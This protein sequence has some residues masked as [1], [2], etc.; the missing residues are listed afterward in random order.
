MDLDL[1]ADRLT[2]DPSIRFLLP[3]HLYGRSMNLQ[4]LQA[5]SERFGVTIIEDCAQAVRASSQNRDVGAVGIASA[6]SMYPTK[7]LGAI[8]DAGFIMTDDD[9]I[10]AAARNL[11][12]YGQ[13]QKYVHD[14]LGLN[15]RLD[16]IHAAILRDAMLPRMD[17]FMA[18]RRSIAEQYLSRIDNPDVQ[19]PRPDAGHVW[20]LFPVRCKAA[21]ELVTWLSRYEVQTGRHYPI[22]IPDQD[23]LSAY[24]DGVDVGGSYPVAQ[25]FA[26]S[27]VSLPIHPYL[28]QAQIDHVI[29]VVNAFSCR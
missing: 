18:R 5:L 19:L 24:V 29:S 21:P 23:A 10:A 2:L 11:R 1:A 13:S 7:N 9:H 14:S 6:V 16:E 20:H 27:E 4:A 8:G 3:V 28:D 15:S 26:A 17:K 25:D 12:D 22:L